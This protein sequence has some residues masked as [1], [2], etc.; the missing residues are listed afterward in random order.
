[1]ACLK[2]SIAFSVWPPLLGVIPGLL[3]FQR[4]LRDLWLQLF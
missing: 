4:R 1:M 3:Y 2:A